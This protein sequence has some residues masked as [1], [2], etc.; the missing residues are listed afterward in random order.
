MCVRVASPSKQPPRRATAPRLFD[1]GLHGIDDGVELL[2]GL[3]LAMARDRQLGVDELLVDVDLE[4]ARAGGGVNIHRQGYLPG[5]FV[6]E[7][8]GECGGKLLVASSASEF[9][10]HLDWLYGGR[11]APCKRYRSM[12]MHCVEKEKENTKQQKNI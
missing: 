8:A 11:A 10:V 2:V 6:L 1:E 9:E 3:H 5:Q 7:E 12:C 4:G